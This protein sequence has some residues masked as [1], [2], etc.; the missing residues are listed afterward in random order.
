[1]PAQAMAVPRSGCEHD[2]SQK[3]HD[4]RGR[5]QQRIAHVVHRLGPGF[6]KIGEK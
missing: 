5:R 2:Q 1:M 6:E 4:R 3:H